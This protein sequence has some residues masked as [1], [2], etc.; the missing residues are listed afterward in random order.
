[1]TSR[2]PRARPFGDGPLAGLGER[3]KHWSEQQW[4]GHLVAR[5]DQ[6]PAIEAPEVDRQGRGISRVELREGAL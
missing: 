1:V 3:P 4:Q 5:A 2:R 6:V